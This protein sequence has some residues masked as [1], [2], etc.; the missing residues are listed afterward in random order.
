MNFKYV[1]VGG[2]ATGAAAI[3]GIRAYDPDGPILLVSRENRAPY[4]RPFLSKDLWFTA[5]A[6]DQLSY[7]PPDFYREQGVELMLRRE[8]VE[9]EPETKTLWDD[10][11]GTLGYD[12]LLLATGV[13]PR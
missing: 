13:R 7:R 6:A 1:I 12:Q 4:R 5:G 11:G 2:G 9:M 8:I 10:R 3:E